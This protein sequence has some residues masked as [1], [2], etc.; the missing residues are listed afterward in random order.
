M[1]LLVKSFTL[2]IPADTGQGAPVSLD[3]SFGALNVDSIE[4]RV[5]PGPRGYMGF[6]IQNSGVVVIP[7]HSDQ[8]I[9]A[10][11][12]AAAWALDGQIT[13]GSWQVAGYN[14]GQYDHSVYF[15]FLLSL[16]PS[17]DA[18]SSSPVLSAA[19]LAAP[20]VGA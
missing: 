10:D 3:V 11:D 9:V 17:P 13:S 14:N 18:A 4:W 5:P 7:S 16:P 8:W 6:Q 15:R 19:A 1:S 20:L 2:L 12:D